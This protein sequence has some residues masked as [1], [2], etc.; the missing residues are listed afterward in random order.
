MLHVMYP[1][2]TGGIGPRI[3]AQVVCVL[4]PDQNRQLSNLRQSS[5]PRSVSPVASIRVG[6]VECR[7]CCTDSIAEKNPARVGV[8]T[9]MYARIPG[10]PAVVVDAIRS[11]SVFTQFLMRVPTCVA[12]VVLGMWEQRVPDVT[13][14]FIQKITIYNLS[15]F[16]CSF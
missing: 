10:R 11:F 1:R 12:M 14:T 15:E 8:L 2:S 3:R 5:L 7:Y 9:F 13:G 16:N 4:E 6:A